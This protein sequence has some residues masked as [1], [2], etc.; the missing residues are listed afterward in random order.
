MAESMSEI[1]D[2]ETRFHAVLA[3][4]LEAAESGTPAQDATWLNRFPDLAEDLEQFFSAVQSVEEF[5]APFRKKTA[6]RAAVL[7]GPRRI[8]DYELLEE[9]GRGGM[10]VVYRARQLSL[11][12]VVAVKMIRA[13]WLATSADAERF[14][15]EA[16]LAARLDHPG[17]VPI[18]EVGE[19]GGCPYFSMKLMAGG[20]L[21]QRIGEFPDDPRRAVELVISVAGAVEHAHQHGIL[22]RDL[23]PSNILL[24]S[25]GRALVADFGLAKWLESDQSQTQTG[26]LLGTPMYMAPEFVHAQRQ[27][28]TLLATTACDVYGLGTILYTLLAGRAPFFGLAPLA[29]LQAVSELDPEPPSR[30]NPRV[31]RDLETIC[32]KCLEKNPHRRYRSAADLADELQ[33]WQRG[34]V[35]LARPVGTC[36]RLYRW[37]RKNPVLAGMSLTAGL[38]LVGLI[39][40]LATGYWMVSAARNEADA[41]RRDA[42]RIADSLRQQ[43]YASEMILGFR[44]AERGELEELRGLVEHYR[45]ETDLQGFEWHW[46]DAQARRRPLVLTCVGHEGKVYA[47]TW[48]ADGSQFATCSEDRTI[49]FWD[50]T[51]GAP[52]E[53]WRP[54]PETAW[55][56]VPGHLHKDDEFAVRFSP[57]GR[58]LASIGEDGTVRLWD[59]ALQTWQALTPGH[60]R[61]AVSVEFSP[62]GRWLVTAG[63]DGRV[64]VWDLERSAPL[65]A[66]TEH[67]TG[68]HYASFSP[69]GTR[70]ASAD[71]NGRVL[72]W[73]REQRTLEHTIQGGEHVFS[74]AFAPDGSLLA[75]GANGG[76]VQLWNPHTGQRIRSLE[77]FT[78]D[79]RSVCFSPD[80]SSLAASSTDGTV[81]I[82][83]VADGNSQHYFK[84]HSGPVWSVRFSADGGRLLTASSDRTARLWKL[85]APLPANHWVGGPASP[86]RRVRVS[87][88]GDRFLVVTV[89]ERLHLGSFSSRNP[90]TTLSVRTSDW[91]ATPVFS[92]DGRELALVQSEH[93][94][95]RWRLEDERPL[96]LIRLD[97]PGTGDETPSPNR[98]RQFTYTADGRF[99]ILRPDGGLR[100]YD[101]QQQRDVRLPV[102]NLEW[103]VLLMALPGE[104][105]LLISDESH[106][107]FRIWN[108][109][110]EQFES[111]MAYP[112]VPQFVTVS[113]D[114]KFLALASGQEI[115]LLEIATAK[116]RTDFIRH[117]LDVG[118]LEF[119][120]DRK[121]LA[122]AGKDGTV[123]L[124]HVA[125]GQELAVLEDRRVPLFSVAFSPDGR[126]L[127]VAGEPDPDT[128]ST[129]TV[130]EI[131]ASPAPHT[132]H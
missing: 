111:N 81:R 26:L 76:Q 56:Q 126:R 25:E 4:Y 130:Y 75:T 115:H 51:T 11:K 10:G 47:A 92:P 48:S 120:P 7:A 38:L 127:L 52:R 32:L 19:V 116:L 104:N 65:P 73:D 30:R 84:A 18:Y 55:E 2:R 1:D 40:G 44:H 58:S 94:L 100:I 122:S 66:F 37:C 34:D 123:R 20:N 86:A 79:V 71:H 9:I 6:K 57:A 5:T 69:D 72:I 31:D 102:R 24:D 83:S 89:D 16:E 118:W 43:L 54:R 35:I 39:V 109:Q 74:V 97:Q 27:A 108:T 53:I 50:G 106:E 23:K 70:V 33:R 15:G 17:I 28:Q 125:T 112:Y 93:Q 87:P 110:T 101:R 124:W 114:G 63:Y 90:L 128:G 67:Q 8:G 107:Q 121:T 36:E 42:Q 59:L 119:S 61:E 85:P 91:T 60:S 129:L 64:L 132:S 105:K 82:W 22:H 46:L 88:D 103:P 113:A 49:R 29:T 95:L 80:G 45:H 98:F 41:H 21:A 14:R 96:P 78:G 62:D 3:E 77:P 13:A 131:P 68:V 12:R 99:W 117:N